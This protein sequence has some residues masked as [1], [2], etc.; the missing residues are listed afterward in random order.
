MTA[1]FRGRPRAAGPAFFTGHILL[2]RGISPNPCACCASAPSQ[3]QSAAADSP[4]LGYAGSGKPS[5]GVSA[6]SMSA[7]SRCRSA[8]PLARPLRE[9][10]SD[11]A[12][13]NPGPGRCSDEHVLYGAYPR[14]PAPSRAFPISLREIPAPG[15][16][17]MS[18]FYTGHIP[19]P[20]RLLCKRAISTPV[21]CRRQPLSGASRL[22][23]PSPG[24]SAAHSLRK[25]AAAP[26]R[27]SCGPCGS[28]FPTLPK[29]AQFQLQSRVSLMLWRSNPPDSAVSGRL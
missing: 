2:I 5:P 7:T 9:S 16:A 26:P 8:A 6:A 14:T 12:A 21:C 4:F 15:G 20:L 18:T 29:P 11:F 22:G 27:R 3:P 1:K 13:R 10:L 24:V 25:L 17:L 28:R 19:E 23:K